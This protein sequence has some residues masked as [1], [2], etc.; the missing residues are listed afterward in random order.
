MPAKSGKQIAWLAGILEGESSFSC[1]DNG[2]STVIK[3]SMNDKDVIERA[4][5]IFNYNGTISESTLKSGS[6]QYI[7]Q[8]Y[9]NEA[10][11]WMM[12]I[13]CLMGNRRKTK[14]KSILILWKDYERQYRTI[15]SRG[16]EV[17][18]D[19]AYLLPNGTYGCKECRKLTNNKSDQ[20]RRSLEGMIAKLHN[21]S[22]EEAKIFIESNK[23]KIH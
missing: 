4:A 22:I 2:T 10:I 18:D 11:Q 13:Y 20:K 23:D 17:I 6:I 8:L 9:G 7:I 21:I 14:I 12:T 3:L 5:D 1:Q 19:N 15:C 16:H